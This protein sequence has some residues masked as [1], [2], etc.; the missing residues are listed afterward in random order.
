MIASVLGLP[1]EDWTAIAACATAAVAVAAGIIAFFQMLEARRLRREQTQ[2]YVVVYADENER[3]PYLIDI[4]VKNLGTTAA[5]DVRIGF[6]PHPTQAARGESEKI[7]IPDVF[8]VLV[9]GQEWRTFWDSA[10]QRHDSGLP[11][12]SKAVATFKDSRGKKEYELDYV[13]DWAT[14]MNRGTIV[15]RGLHDAAEALRDIS[16]SVRRWS[17]GAGVKG[18]SVY[19]RSGDARDERMREAMEERRRGQTPPQQPDAH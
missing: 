4:V 3:G 11:D 7:A 15:T 13:L 10:I 16:K 8:P 14:V 1:A 2:P 9:P 19:T 18:L 5:T 12:R 17:E 6:D